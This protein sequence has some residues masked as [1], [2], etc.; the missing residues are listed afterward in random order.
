MGL[1]D[2]ASLEAWGRCRSCHFGL[3]TPNALHEA[4]RP[5]L[6]NPRG[7]GLMTAMAGL[8]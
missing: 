8:S 2:H 6:K 3:S 1:D 5:Y 7:L 4:W